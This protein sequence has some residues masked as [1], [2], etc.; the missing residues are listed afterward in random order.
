MYEMKTWHCENVVVAAVLLV[1]WIW[2]GV[3]AVELLGSV[4][5]FCGFY[6]A[7]ISERLREREAARATPAVECHQKAV[8]FFVA[9][10]LG[11]AAYFIVNH[12]WSALVGCALFA[13]YP[14]WRRYY[15]G[16]KPLAAQ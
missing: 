16:I 6:H 7:S 8:L 15:R 4:A 12:S 9:K 14:L 10:E 2:T 3:R 1:V 13:A 11:W 5:V